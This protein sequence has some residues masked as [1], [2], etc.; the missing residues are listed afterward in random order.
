MPG[1]DKN[2]LGCFKVE[3]LGL[4]TKE[5]QAAEPDP[6][7][8]GTIFSSRKDKLKRLEDARAG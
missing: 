4:D 1:S 2:E 7:S 8:G 5:K 6:F 3:L